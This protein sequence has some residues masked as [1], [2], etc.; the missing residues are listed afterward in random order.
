MPSSNDKMLIPTSNRF[1]VK[2]NYI[3]YPIDSVDLMNALARSNLGYVIAQTPRVK[4]PIGAKFDAVGLIARKGGT[5]VDFDY[6]SQIIGV[7]G[8]DPR[9]VVATMAEVENI[10]QNELRINVEENVRFYEASSN[11]QV[12]TGKNPLKILAQIK[13]PKEFYDSIG[14]ILGI[15]ITTEAIHIAAISD[16]IESSEWFDMYIRPLPNRSS[17]VYDVTTIFRRPTREPVAEFLSAIEVT[18]TKLFDIIESYA[19]GK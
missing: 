5:G 14:K 11:Y 9:E 8:L 16:T 3:L 15:S 6:V 4:V 17:T 7:E 2:R 18:T 19:G 13:P 10:I 12:E 1:A